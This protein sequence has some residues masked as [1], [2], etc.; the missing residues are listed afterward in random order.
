MAED[1]VPFYISHSTAHTK[2]LIQLKYHTFA[3]RRSITTIYSVEFKP[4]IDSIQ[5]Y[6]QVCVSNSVSQHLQEQILGI[7]P[8]L[9]ELAEENVRKFP[10]AQN[11]VVIQYPFLRYTIENK[12]FLL[13]I[14]IDTIVIL[15]QMSPLFVVPYYQQQSKKREN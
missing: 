4:N 6:K 12:Y 5:S 2:Q 13:I 1:L 15:F 14:C 3:T 9:D 7:P 11:A 10:I 8:V